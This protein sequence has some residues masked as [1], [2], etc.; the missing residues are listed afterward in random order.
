MKPIKAVVK[1]T[2]FDGK[3]DCYVLDD[4]RRVIS[5]RGIVRGISGGRESGSLDR[6]LTRLPLG[7]SDLKLGPE[8][9]II[10][11]HGSKAIARNASDFVTICDAYV[12]AGLAGKL[13]PSQAHM[14]QICR[15]FQKSLQIVGVVALID[16]ATNY[17]AVR[18]SDGLQSLFERLF[19]KQIADWSI[20]WK[21]SLIMAMC[22]LYG[23]PYDG[24]R[25]PH[26]LSSPMSMI[27][28][29]VLGEDGYAELKRRNK[30][31]RFGSNHHQFLTDEVQGLLDDD[32]RTI[33][34]LANQSGSPDEFRRRLFSHYRK[35]PLQLGFIA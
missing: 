25:I 11:V 34:L 19:R 33:E 10:T 35:Q 8:I 9:E 24:G 21:P 23:H 32:L 1:G 14:A 20:K 4:E 15:G 22:K 6:Y 16:E 28:E 5:Q 27:Y 2:L 26:W 31:P 12:D 30:E 17:Q 7:F 13:H 29:T 3:V 18:A